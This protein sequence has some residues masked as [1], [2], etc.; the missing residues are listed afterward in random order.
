MTN[1]KVIGGGLSGCEAALQLAD[2]G[3]QVELW[4]MRPRVTTPA[5]KTGNLAELVCS[6]SFKG[7]AF[8]S[9]HGLFKEE[10]R[11]MG[12][13]LLAHAMDSRVPAGESLAID[14]DLFSS[15]VEGAI[16]SHPRIALRREE[17]TG[18][19]PE[20]PT[21]VATGPLSSENL[22]K[23]LFSLIGSERLYFFDSIA[24]VVELDSLDPEQTFA[25]NRWEKGQKEGQEPD[26]INCP[27]DKETYFAFVEALRQADT[28]EAKPFEKGQLFEGCL[29]V[30]EM[31]RRGVETLRYGPMRPVGLR[32]PR[33]GKTPF[34]VIQLRAENRQR[35]LYNLVGFQT[36]LK[37]GT[38]KRIFSMVPALREAAYARFGAMHRN[39]FLNSPQVLEPSMRIKGTRIFCAGQIT[40]AEGYTEAIGTGMYA[41]SM[42]LAHLR[43]DDHFSWPEASCLGAL[44]RH[45][46]DPN[47]DFQPMNFNFG[48]L[49]K[50]DSRS[51]KDR[52]GAQIE[53]CLQA[54]ESFQPFPERA[55]LPADRFAARIPAA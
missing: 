8:T 25:K 43:G 6:N 5:H 33:T 38:Q 30:E 23:S 44:T 49:P 54:L 26:F 17:A 19:N 46:T 9:A 7:L 45:L 20:E 53:Q 52:K 14:R 10:L 22:T 48:L 40:G 13:R 42:M 16:A 41:A 2:A 50:V 51:K 36:R 29:P 15:A 11:R 4:E 55:A 28:V 18:L 37:W 35:T 47:P 32:D 1:V 39:T 31:A 24:P 3:H 34:A 21:L 27:L 12:S